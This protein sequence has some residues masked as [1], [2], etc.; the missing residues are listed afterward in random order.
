MSDRHARRRHSSPDRRRGPTAGFLTADRGRFR[1]LA[2]E[3]ITGLSREHR[4][5][6]AR[7]RVVV[8]DVPPSGR[9]R[10]VTL[11]RLVPMPVERPTG[12]A[13]PGEATATMVLYRR[14]IEMRAT[15]RDELTEIIRQVVRGEIARHRGDDPDADGR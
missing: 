2:D 5:F 9:G 3:A 12:T 7:V 15:S 10:E 4:E 11:G 8:E 13:G 1:R 6:L 14:P